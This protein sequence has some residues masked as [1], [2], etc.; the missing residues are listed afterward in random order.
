M[1]DI[2]ADGANASDWNNWFSYGEEFI[3]RKLAYFTIGNHDDDNSPSGYDNIL[4]LYTLPGN[5]KYYSFNL[6][7]CPV[8]L[9]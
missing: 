4:G 5:E 3:A 8:Y 9:P 7:E 1:G 6:R 2:V